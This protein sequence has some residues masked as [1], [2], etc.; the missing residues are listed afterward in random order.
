MRINIITLIATALISLS[1]SAQIQIGG[2]KA[3]YDETTKSY[4][5]VTDSASIKDLS[6]SVVATDA[7]LQIL[8][9]NGESVGEE[10]HF[11]DASTDRIYT[12]TAASN[13]E[14]VEYSLRF[15]TLSI[16]E[17]TKDNAFTDNYETAQLIVDAPDSSF[18]NKE[19]SCKVKH[20]GGSTNKSWKHKRNYK[21]KIL[22]DKG[23]SEDV[24]FFGMREDNGWILD[25]GQVDLFRMRN[26]VLHG[27]WL[28][29]S[30][31][32]YYSAEEPKTVN[33]C[34]TKEIELF[35]NNQYRGIYN[36]MEP[37]DRKQL[38]L[39]KYKDKDGVHGV[40]Y[41]TESWDGTNFGSSI[42]DPY[43]NT[44]PTW[45]GWEAKYPEPG[46]DADTTDY[47]PLNDFI[48]FVANSSDSTFKSDIS[49][50]LDIPVF[51]DYTLFVTLINGID[52]CAKN[53]YWS[54]YDKTKPEFDK[55]VVTPWDLDA[56]T[57]QFYT[58]YI[59]GGIDSTVIGP[60]N[61][62]FDI[63][64][65][66][67]RLSSACGDEYVNLLK[68]R[69]AELRETWFSYESLA[70]RFEDA[71]NE[72]N[73]CG[74]AKREETKWSGDND[75]SHLNLNFASQLEYIK[76][77]F[78]KRLEFLDDKFDYNSSTGIKDIQSNNPPHNAL[79]NDIYNLQGQK[80]SPSYH[81]IVIRN[82]KKFYQ[83]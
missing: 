65:I 70:K 64:N 29:F 35:I 52:N 25:A 31:K 59:E 78:K 66:G 5:V 58:N 23:K 63:T 12:L 60:S 24:S 46:D 71:Y 50:K 6:A 21:F 44:S 67:A 32:P 48:D 55:F 3:F 57:G 16:I 81:G 19:F 77:W 61:E 45:H 30:T 17:I 76:N 40:L 9:I 33:G 34:H 49:Q 74:A 11:G 2:H 38:K 42:A 69:Y 53:M 15:T 14:P 82:G 27:L 56:T 43:S 13:G 62:L 75:I 26:K 39:K 8:K 28:D 7:T 41:K 47:K 1:A 10:F 73:Y 79:N 37:V 80:V 36:L 18:L 20:R 72:I 22:D 54:V 4:L 68:N 83:K 51:I